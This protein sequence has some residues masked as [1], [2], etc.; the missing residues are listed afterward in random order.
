MKTSAFTESLN[1]VLFRKAG[2]PCRD[3]RLTGFRRHFE[4]SVNS[5]LFYYTVGNLLAYFAHQPGPLVI[6][7]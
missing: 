2:G 7:E 5:V 1:I 6:F 3:F 4:N